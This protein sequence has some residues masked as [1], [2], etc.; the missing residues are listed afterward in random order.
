MLSETRP[1]RAAVTV[2]DRLDP[3]QICVGNFY[4]SSRNRKRLAAL[5]GCGKSLQISVDT[6]FQRRPVDA[7]HKAGHDDLL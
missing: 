5:A 4:Q 6:E 7:R 2:F 1:F 3:R